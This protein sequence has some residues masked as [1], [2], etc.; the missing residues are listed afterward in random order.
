MA[1]AAGQLHSL[2]LKTNGTIVAWGD[3]TDGQLN[4]SDLS[5]VMAVAAGW[6]HSVFLKN[7]GTVLAR[8]YNAD[9]ETTTPTAL[10]TTTVKMIAAG[11]NQTVALIFSPLTQYQVDVTKDLLL[12]YNSTNADS[13]NVFAYYTN[14]RPMVS[15]ANRLPISCTNNETVLSTEIQ[16]QILTRARRGGK[17]AGT[18]IESRRLGFRA[19]TTSV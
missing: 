19:S 17:K 11:A 12:I 5:N 9:G 18:K 4:V 1:I 15:A 6:R 2:A 13:S 10:G 16:S 14:N 8:G 7:D 3:N